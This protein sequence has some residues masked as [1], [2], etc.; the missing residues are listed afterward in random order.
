MIEVTKY[1]NP[2][3]TSAGLVADI[4]ETEQNSTP[5]PSAPWKP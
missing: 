2:P 4:L 5:Q 3:G 1:Q